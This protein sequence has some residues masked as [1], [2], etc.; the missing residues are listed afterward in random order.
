MS[1]YSKLEAKANR[2][3][4]KLS[5]R[6]SRDPEE[7]LD[8]EAVEKYEKELEKIERALSKLEGE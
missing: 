1:M 2:I 4:Q 7:E 3:R 8:K 6:R 5:N